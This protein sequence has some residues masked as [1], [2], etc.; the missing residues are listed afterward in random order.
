MQLIP[1]ND[2]G[3]VGIIRDTPPYQLPP[4]VWS[5]GN[6]VRFLD[7]GVKKCA[8]YEE[9]FATL[10]FAAYYIIPFIDNGGT[11]HW[12]AFGLDNAAV[13]TGSAWVDITRQN[14]TTLN[15]SLSASDV[16]IVLTDSSIFP[17]SGSIAIGTNETG[18]ATTNLYEEIDYG[19]NNTGTNT[20]SS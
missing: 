10:P 4:N 6:N 5:N 13:W 15:G 16:T 20:L 9:V 1:I 14:T 8:G 7:N 2:V 17:S 11:Y 18:D 19:A 3:Q 12:V